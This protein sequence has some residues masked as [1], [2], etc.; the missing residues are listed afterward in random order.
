MCVCV[1]VCVCVQPYKVRDQSEY[2][3]KSGEEEND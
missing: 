2:I 1:C 3:Y